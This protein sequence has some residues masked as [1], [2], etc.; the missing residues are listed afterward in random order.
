T[1]VAGPPYRDPFNYVF[2]PLLITSIDAV[3]A[4]MINRLNVEDKPGYTRL[5]GAVFSTWW[6]GGLRTIP[7]FHNMVGILTEVH[8]NPT[9][10]QVPLVLDR[11]IPDNNTPNPI[12]PRRT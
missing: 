5:D 8:G 2:D 11:L 9:P 6:N 12:G 7:Y 3:G 1:I 4:A 10:S